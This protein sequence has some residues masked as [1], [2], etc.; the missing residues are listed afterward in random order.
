MTIDTIADYFA[1]QGIVVSENQRA[2]L[3]SYVDLLKK[4]NA[5][6]HLI[7]KGDVAHI[8]ER[9]ILPSFLFAQ[10]ARNK[11]V[12]NTLNV[13][14]LGTGAGLPGIIMAILFPQSRF[15]L[16]ESSRKKTLFLRQVKKDLKLKFNV[17][18][19]R[20]EQWQERKQIKIDII[21]ARAVASIDELVNLTKDVLVV[22]GAVLLTVKSCELKEPISVSV[23]KEFKISVIENNLWQISDYLKDKCLVSLEFLHGRKETV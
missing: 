21:T 15:W 3:K 19:E 14:D 11:F 10:F 23:K 9:H 7:S 6:I 20:F 1:K 22:Q 17:I 16:V 18:N 5:K 2:Q 8:E 13:V 4:W 12:D